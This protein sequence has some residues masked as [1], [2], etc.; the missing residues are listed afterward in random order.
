[1]AFAV[2]LLRLHAL[3]C[4]YL[5]ILAYTCV[6]LR[7]HTFI[8]NDLRLLRLPRM[9]SN[10]GERAFFCTHVHLRSPALYHVLFENVTKNRFFADER[11]LF[12][13]ILNFLKY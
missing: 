8:A 13:V 3:T 10:A 12:A 9:G 1:M 6:Y 2:L 5:R 7:L 4:V 11:D